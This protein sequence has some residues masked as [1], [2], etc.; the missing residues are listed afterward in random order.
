MA[1]NAPWLDNFT[2]NLNGILIKDRWAPP[3]TKPVPELHNCALC[4][5][6]SKSQEFPDLY[7]R[8]K[9]KPCPHHDVAKAPTPETDSPKLCPESERWELVRRK[10]IPGGRRNSSWSTKTLGYFPTKEAA[11]AAQKRLESNS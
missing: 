11:E 4:I 9:R 6:N 1:G 3:R 8:Y 2:I 5:K 10:W 7:K